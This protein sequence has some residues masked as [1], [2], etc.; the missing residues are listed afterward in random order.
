MGDV[1]AY[2]PS[3]PKDASGPLDISSFPLKLA[4]L[5]MDPKQKGIAKFKVE[6][7][8]E[9]RMLHLDNVLYGPSW[10]SL[11]QDFDK[12]PLMDIICFQGCVFLRSCST[13]EGSCSTPEGR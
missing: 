9:V 13:P 6:L 5:S 3:P 8:N 4:Q 10:R 12:K 7:T 2:D 1:R 11:I